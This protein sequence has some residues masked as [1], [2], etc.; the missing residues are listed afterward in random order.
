[1]HRDLSAIVCQN[2]VSASSAGEK[3]QSFSRIFLAHYHGGIIELLVGSYG[4][5]ELEFIVW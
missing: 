2:E 5:D 1:V 3:K 4:Q